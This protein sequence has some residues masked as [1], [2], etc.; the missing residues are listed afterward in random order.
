MNAVSLKQIFFYAP[1]EL[2]RVLVASAALLAAV[3]SPECCLE[4]MIF[5]WPSYTDA[6]WLAQLNFILSLNKQRRLYT[7]TFER[8]RE[9]N[10]DLMDAVTR[11]DNNF[12]YEFLRR[13]EWDL[14]NLLRGYKP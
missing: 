6:T 12:L 5:S 14:Q 13:N 10:I 3:D 9:G 11:I 4:N 8:V 2:S 1:T 7:S